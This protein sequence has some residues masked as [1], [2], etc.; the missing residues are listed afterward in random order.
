MKSMILLVVLLISFSACVLDGGED[1]LGGAQIDSG[2]TLPSENT[3]EDVWPEDGT[4]QPR[5]R[6]CPGSPTPNAGCPADCEGD[7][8]CLVV[9]GCLMGQ[10]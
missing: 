7:E 8:A 4:V 10:G 5:P 9:C 2:S 6:Y 3:A 1:D